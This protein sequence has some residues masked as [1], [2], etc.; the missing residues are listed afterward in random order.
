MPRII[1]RSSLFAINWNNFGDQKSAKNGLK[2]ENELVNFYR[3]NKSAV[4]NMVVYLFWILVSILFNDVDSISFP[5]EFIQEIR[6]ELQEQ[7]R[8]V[9]FNYLLRL[10]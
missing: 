1:K 10:K 8:L 7:Y 2:G 3:N 5:K 9:Y 4:N 6:Q